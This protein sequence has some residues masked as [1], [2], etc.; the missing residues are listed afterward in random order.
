[1]KTLQVKV[2]FVCRY[3]TPIVV[4][5]S[6]IITIVLLVYPRGANQPQEEV[7]YYLFT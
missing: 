3:A 6:V 7:S 2:I 4:L 1:M 5:V